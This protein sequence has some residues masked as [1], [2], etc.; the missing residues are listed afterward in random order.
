MSRKLARLPAIHPGEIL[1]DEYMKPLGLSPD[2]LS[3]ELYVP[4]TRI[5]E[6]VNERRGISADT[7]LRLG[8]YFNNKSGV[9]VETPEVS[10]DRNSA[11]ASPEDLILTASVLH[12]KSGSLEE[13]VGAIGFGQLAK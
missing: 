1:R 4:V 7:A 6:I 5:S 2:S 13:I 8:R 12:I 9:L 10:R 3:C 11:A